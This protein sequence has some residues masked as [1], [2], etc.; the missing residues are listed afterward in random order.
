VYNFGFK[1]NQVI[2]LDIKG[3]SVLKRACGS[4]TKENVT[5]GN[6]MEQRFQSELQEVHSRVLLKHISVIGPFWW[7]VR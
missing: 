6:L 4:S 5:K 1:I 7:F 3:I 2:M